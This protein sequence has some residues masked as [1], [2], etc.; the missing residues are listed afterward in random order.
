IA[1]TALPLEFS[2][3][4]RCLIL[5]ILALPVATAAGLW[6]GALFADP[7]WSHPRA[8]LRVPGRLL[9]ALVMIVQTIGWIVLS[10]NP[11]RSPSHL[12]LAV[13]AAGVGAVVSALLLAAGSA[14]STATGRRA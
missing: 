13:L 8:M 12:A 9:S 6:V 3:A 10:Q 4:I 11:L 1:L 5:G 2:V 14:L 7:E